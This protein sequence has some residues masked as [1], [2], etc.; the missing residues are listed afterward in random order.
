VEPC[1]HDTGTEF[2]SWLNGS[3]SLEQAIEASEAMLNERDRSVIEVY[4]GAFKL[5]GAEAIE[6]LIHRLRK[7]LEASPV[8]IATLR[9]LGYQLEST[10]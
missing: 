4:R 5:P 2:V 6:V 9:G 7:R 10:P 3:Q 8:R 1:Y